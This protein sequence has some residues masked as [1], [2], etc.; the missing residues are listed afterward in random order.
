MDHITQ[1]EGKTQ[2]RKKI[3][4][5][6]SR[7]VVRDNQLTQNLHV[8]VYQELIDIKAHQQN[9]LYPLMKI[10]MLLR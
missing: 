10:R 1:I 2:S 8:L 5:E 3:S 4:T 7:M 6:K 9:I